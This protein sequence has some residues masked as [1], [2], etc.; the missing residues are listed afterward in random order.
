MDYHEEILC[1]R[2]LH[3]R[4]YY[5]KQHHLT[6]SSHDVVPAYGLNLVVSLNLVGDNVE[7]NHVCLFAIGNLPELTDDVG[8][9]VIVEDLLQ[10]GYVYHTIRH[11]IPSSFESYVSAGDTIWNSPLSYWPISD[12]EKIDIA[13]WVNELKGYPISVAA[14]KKSLKYRWDNLQL[15]LHFL[16]EGKTWAE[17]DQEVKLRKQSGK[18]SR[19]VVYM[20]SG[21]EAKRRRTEA[22]E[23]V[24][25]EPITR[26]GL[27]RRLLVETIQYHTTM[28]GHLW[29]A[30]KETPLNAVLLLVQF[31]MFTAIANKLYMP[32]SPY[33]RT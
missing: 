21:R 20:E 6:A 23:G 17:A 16:G 10:S 8:L 29:V 7:K 5:K 24:E 4:K 12:N 31:K 13:D 33:S 3:G 25:P 2:R 28:R 30:F 27:L 1:E 14:E 9:S 22:G 32:P 26:R 19:D 15:L 11:P 18:I